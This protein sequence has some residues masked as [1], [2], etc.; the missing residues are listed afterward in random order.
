MQARTRVHYCHIT[1]Y[2]S[3]KNAKK[4][5]MLIFCVN[6]IAFDRLRCCVNVR[7]NPRV[8]VLAVDDQTTAAPICDIQAASKTSAEVR[9]LRKRGRCDMLFDC[10][11]ICDD[12]LRLIIFLNVI[13]P[14]P[15]MCSFMFTC[16]CCFAI[17]KVLLKKVTY[18]LTTCS[19]TNKITARCKAARRVLLLNTKH[20]NS[21]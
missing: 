11:H 10:L 3:N 19:V 8:K 12:Y 21:S 5:I 1:R 7:R 16:Q 18:L 20:F 4:I 9:R 13:A 15:V 6:G 2:T 17:V 14:R